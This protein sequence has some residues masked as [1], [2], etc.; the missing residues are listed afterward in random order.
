M[1]DD[2]DRIIEILTKHNEDLR[3][4]HH[5][6]RVRLN[7]LEQFVLKRALEAFQRGYNEESNSELFAAFG[8]IEQLSS[9]FESMSKRKVPPRILHRTGVVMLDILF[10]YFERM[11]ARENVEFTLN[12]WGNVQS[13]VQDCISS[14]KLQVL[15]V[16]LLQ[17]A[18]AAIDAKGGDLHKLLVNIGNSGHHYLLSVWDS[19]VGFTPDMLPKL[20]KEKV[21]S[22]GGEDGGNGYVEIFD[23]LNQ[24]NASLIIEEMDIG[25]SPGFLKMITL[26]FD[27]RN[28]RTFNKIDL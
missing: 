22:K 11:C 26:Q 12:I 3:S 14:D 20:G 18:I 1:K 28:K 2:K 27:G 4:I 17:N 8:G 23:I 9:E 21:T 15:I 25:D 6:I 16:N 24:C 5:N 19:G 10:E 13:M 7:A